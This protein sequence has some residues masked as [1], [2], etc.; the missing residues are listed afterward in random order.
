VLGNYYSSYAVLNYLQPHTV[1]TVLDQTTLRKGVLGKRL[2]NP[3]QHP[4]T[5]VISYI[6]IQYFSIMLK[7]P[8]FA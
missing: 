1:K 5:A 7:N 8:N 4:S 2:P 6:Q 3:I